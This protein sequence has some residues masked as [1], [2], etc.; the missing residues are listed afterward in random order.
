MRE[1]R[2]AIIGTGTISHRHMMIYEN[3]RQHSAEIGFTAKVVAAAEINEARRKAWGE[4]Y[5]VSE[6]DL[7]T[8]FREMLKRDDIDT[9]DV[10]VHNNLHVPIAIEVMKRGYDC[11]LE[12]PPAASYHD[13]KL[14]VDAAKALNRKL[15]VQISSLMRYQTKAAREMVLRGDLGNVYYVNLENVDHRNRT[16]YD[17]FFGMI[18]PPFTPDY[19]TRSMAGHGKSIDIGVYLISQILFI[20]GLPKLKSVSGFSCTGL[21]TDPAMIERDEGFGVEDIADGF[22]RFENG[23][24]FHFLSASAANT[25]CY[26]MSYI[27]GSK[28]GLEITATDV[29]GGRFARRPGEMFPEGNP[30]LTFRGDIGG[31]DVSVCLNCNDNEILELRKDPK[32]YIYNDNQVMWLA[33]YLGI[34]DDSTR[35][36]T[37]EIALSM[38]EFTDGIFL[39]NELGRTV[40]RDEII[41]MSPQLFIPEQEI[42]GELVKY[43]VEF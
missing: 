36:N 38:L 34:L 37:P 11:Y 19:Y 13:A 10:C 6:E 35:Y 31:K 39:S 18:K 17:P 5:H 7:Y 29:Y 27:L 23:L 2:V 22:A 20:L 40:T 12:K 9:V 25:K 28:G 4:R 42:G 16:G 15:H 3:I 41:S 8:D 1:V 14:A 24:G 26:T 33:Y 30:E 21:P 43:D 32:A